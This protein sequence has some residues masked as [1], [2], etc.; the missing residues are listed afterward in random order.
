MPLRL[1]LEKQLPRIQLLITILLQKTEMKK[2]IGKQEKK[3]GIMNYEAGKKLEKS[4]N[5]ELT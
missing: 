4:E 5:L 2:S 1:I 3:I